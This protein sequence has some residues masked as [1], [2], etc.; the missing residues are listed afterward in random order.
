V[1]IDI[2]TTG[3]DDRS[4]ILQISAI[5]DNGMG[6][7]SDLPFIDLPIKHQSIP[8]SEP[9]TLGMNA[10]LLKKMMD[11]NFTTYSPLHAI[12]SLLVFLEKYHNYSLDNNGKPLKIMF[13]GKNVAIFDIPKIRAFIKRHADPHLPSLEGAISL[14]RFDKI[15]HHK[16]LDVGSLYY[17]TFQDNV[18]LSKINELTGRPKVSHNSLDDAMDVVYGIRHKLGIK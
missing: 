3:I 2:E 10:D 8:Y 16:T 14:E 18:S 9:Y 6:A 1:S 13:A 5:Y 17:D 4:E 11:E 15:T 12:N 7:I